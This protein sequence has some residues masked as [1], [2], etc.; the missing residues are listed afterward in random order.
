MKIPVT[1]AAKT[2]RTLMPKV[3]AILAA[4]SMKNGS[5]TM[6]ISKSVRGS[7]SQRSLLKNIWWKMTKYFV[8]FVDIRAARAASIANKNI[9]PPQIVRG[10]T[11]HKS[12]LIVTRRRIVTAITMTQQRRIA[13]AA[14]KRPRTSSM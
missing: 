14:R 3:I 6:L 13:M 5:G 10:S 2:T 9:V 12:A 4:V 7:K 1:Q 8:K 11:C